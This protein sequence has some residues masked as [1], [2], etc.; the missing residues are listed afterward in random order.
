MPGRFGRDG[1]AIGG[2]V[3]RRVGGRA[4]ALA[5]HVVGIAE[6][7]GRTG[8]AERLGNRLSQHEMGAEQAHGLARRG[9]HGGQAQPLAECLQDALGRLAGM[10]DPGGDAERPRGGGD[11]PGLRLGGPVRPIGSRQLVLDERVGRPRIRHAQ[12]RLG[13]HH[14]G[15]PLL[16]GQRIL[17]QEILDAAETARARAYRLDQVPGAPVDP[18]LGLARQ[19]RIGQQAS[20]NGLVSLGIGS[21][22]GEVGWHGEPRCCSISL[23]Y[24]N[25]NSDSIACLCLC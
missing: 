1:V 17:A 25:L 14:Q 20:G 18:Y 2:E 8:A 9:A 11:Q 19:R 16:G 10:D 7:A 12:Q 6:T 3:A 21:I 23:G 5:E 22:E 15:E 13:Q 4:R 24:G